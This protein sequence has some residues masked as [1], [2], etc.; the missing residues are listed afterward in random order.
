MMIGV[1]NNVLLQQRQAKRKDTTEPM[2][3]DDVLFCSKAGK[4]V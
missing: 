3:T 1:S 2:E 4:P